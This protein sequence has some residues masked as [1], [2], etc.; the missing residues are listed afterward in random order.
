MQKRASEETMSSYEFT[1][2]AFERAFAGLGEHFIVWGP[3][4]LT[5]RGRF[6][7]DDLIDYGQINHFS[8][9]VTEQ[10]SDLSPKSL[11]LP[12]DET[13]F[14]FNGQKFTEAELPEEQHVIV[15]L[16]PCDINGIDRLDKIFLENGNVEDFY[17]A[18]R[19]KR[20]HFFM[21]ECRSSFENCFCVAMKANITSNYAAAFRFLDDKIMVEVVDHN[22]SQYFSETGKVSTFKPDFVEEDSVTVQLPGVD[23]MPQEMYGDSMWREYDSRCIACGRCNVS[24]V[25]CSCFTTRDLFY[26]DSRTCGERRRVWDG[27]HIDGFC[28]MAGGHSFRK[29]KGDR[30]RFKTFH[31]VYDFK[32]KFGS[33]MCV[34]CGRCDDQCPE[35]ISF[36]N[37]INKLSR[38]IKE[39]KN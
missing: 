26:Q 37:C 32:K 38:R 24:C 34:G 36:S 1:F 33:D 9:L 30:M 2:T 15:F 10:K 11:V 14:Y 19:R 16:R 20:L 4:R 31:K 29:E 18:R 5:G 22:F 12:A 35:Y 3:K 39:I 8:D 17:Y 6:V 7:D 25:T 23:E 27:C 13:L 28:D 21:I